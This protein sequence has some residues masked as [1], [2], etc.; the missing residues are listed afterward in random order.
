MADPKTRFSERQSNPEGVGPF[1]FDIPALAPGETHTINLRERQ[2]GQYVVLSPAGYDSLTVRNETD[3]VRLKVTVNETNTVPV[4][5]NTQPNLTI[6]GMY[7][8]DI[9]N[10]EPAGGSSVSDGDASITVLKESY[11][12]DEQAR[13]RKN[14]SVLRGLVRNYTG[15]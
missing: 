13:E 12:A 6:K 7:R 2:N 5:A 14:E 3:N 9:T 15:V 1:E 4:P 8:F 10:T 11:G